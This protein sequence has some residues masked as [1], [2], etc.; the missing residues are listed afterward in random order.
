VIRTLRRAH[1]VW[2]LVLA[3]VLP[4]SLLLALAIRPPAV[5]PSPADPAGWESES[6]VSRAAVRLAP[7]PFVLTAE[8]DGGLRLDATGRPGTLPPGLFL[9]ATTSDDVAAG[10][11]LPADAVLLG[12]AT[13]GAG[14]RAPRSPSAHI[15]LYSLAT[16]AIVGAG[17]P[18]VA[19]SR[20]R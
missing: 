9:Y 15:V 11:P 3:P 13:P 7:S 6:T 17:E 1:G 5:L 18:P 12:A 2:W 4:G 19:A 14:M 16:G 10:D 8:P 20:E